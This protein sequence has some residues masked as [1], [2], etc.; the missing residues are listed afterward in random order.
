MCR[1]GRRGAEECGAGVDL[2]FGPAVAGA[3]VVAWATG[4][5]VGGGA[6]GAEAELACGAAAASMASIGATDA[7]AGADV[8]GTVS[9]VTGEGRLRPRYIAPEAVATSTNPPTIAVVARRLRSAG[10]G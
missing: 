7:T 5:G 1:D 6:D 3:E 9:V 10:S 4:V 8:A 2:V